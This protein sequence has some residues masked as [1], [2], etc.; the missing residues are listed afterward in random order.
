MSEWSAVAV[1]FDKA[2][3]TLREAQQRKYEALRDL[4]NEAYEP[5]SPAR[6]AAPSSLMRPHFSPDCTGHFHRGITEATDPKWGIRP[7][8]QRPHDLGP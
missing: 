7:S 8:C 2:M 5:D 3:H 6:N 4:L 1:R